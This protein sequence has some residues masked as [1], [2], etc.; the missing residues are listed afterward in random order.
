MIKTDFR[1]GFGQ[2]R[3]P[4][5]GNAGAGVISALKTPGVRGPRSEGGERRQSRRERKKET[6]E[7]AARTE[8]MPIFCGG[9]GR[10]TF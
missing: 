8:F 3:P 4:K 1:A 9:R 10:E 7:Q 6:G 5:A 2:K